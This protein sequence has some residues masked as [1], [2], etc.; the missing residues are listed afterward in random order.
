MNENTDSNVQH[1]QILIQTIVKLLKDQVKKN[2]VEISQSLFSF[3]FVILY[4]FYA[5]YFLS[6]F[7]LLIFAFLFC[8]ALKINVY[9]KITPFYVIFFLW[10][11]LSSLWTGFSHYDHCI[12]TGVAYN[13]YT[14]FLIMFVQ[15]FF[16][17]IPDLELDESKKMKENTKNYLILFFNHS[18]ILNFIE[19]SKYIVTTCTPWWLLLLKT[20]FMITIWNCFSFSNAL[21]SRLTGLVCIFTWPFLLVFYGLVLL[22]FLFINFEFNRP[23]LPVTQ[24]DKSKK[25][26]KK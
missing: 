22:K 9:E 14:L 21:K 4:Y 16:V 26:D 6:F 17:A 20:F 13:F 12:W 18:W 5:R 11:I 7:V 2:H 25:K 24:K 15:L 1:L 8:S 3:L 23:S 19:P 10:F